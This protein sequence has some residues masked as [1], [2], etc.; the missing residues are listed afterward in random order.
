MAISEY[1]TGAAQLVADTP[2]GT[3]QQDFI[4]QLNA[5]GHQLIAQGLPLNAERVMRGN[6]W[7]V[8]GAAAAPVTA[9]PTTTAQNSLFNGEGAGGKAL[10][11]DSFMLLVATSQ[12]AA[13]SFGLAVMLNPPTIVAPASAGIALRSLS[14]KSNYGG[15]AV[16]A[17][18][19][20]SLINSGWMPWGTSYNEVGTTNL[21]TQLDIPVNGSIIVPPQGMLNMSVL[22]NAATGTIQLG[23]RW[24]EVQLALG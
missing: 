4:I 6:S 16:F 23:V 14:G 1:P 2:I 8:L 10:I 18:G 24:H 5:L 20:S 17:A 9:L 21:M 7:W 13:G 3:E 12:T 19:L 11:I 22:A 15:K